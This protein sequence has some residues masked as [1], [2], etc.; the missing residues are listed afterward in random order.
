ME[1]G[2]RRG[3][4]KREQEGRKQ[5]GSHFPGEFF[6]GAWTS[7][8]GR[9][10]A[11]LVFLFSLSFSFSLLPASPLADRTRRKCVVT[12]EFNPFFFA[13]RVPFVS[14]SPRLSS[15]HS[16]SSRPISQRCIARRGVSTSLSPWFPRRKIRSELSPVSRTG[17]LVGLRSACPPPA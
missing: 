5:G 7:G 8:T 15:L 9:D 3:S 10:I 11:G 4:K 13:M 1:E 12:H 14:R 16:S 6:S 2:G 17:P